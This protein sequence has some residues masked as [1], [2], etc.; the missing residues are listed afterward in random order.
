MR[1]SKYVFFPSLYLFP[2]RGANILYLYIYIYIYIVGTEFWKHLCAEHGVSED[3]TPLEMPTNMSGGA[4]SVD[5]KD[6]FFYEADDE[7]YVPR[8][9]LLDLEPSVVRHVQQS[10]YG[11][12]YNS[13]NMFTMQSGAGNNWARGYNEAEK[14]ASRVLRMIDREAEECDSLE[15][16]ML[17]HS[18]AGGTGSGM[19]SYLL[20]AL[21]DNYPKKVTASYSVFPQA[22]D[23]NVV[24]GPY[25]SMLTMKRLALNADAVVVLDNAAL[26]RIASDRLR[27]EAASVEDVNSLAAT[28][29]AATTSTIRFPGFLNSSLTSIVASL[30]P[31][32]RCHFLMSSYTPWTA[33]AGATVQSVRKTSVLDVMRRLLDSSNL[34]ASTS[35]RRGQFLSLLNIVQ[36]DS[37]DSTQV[38]KGLQ[39]IRE[40]KLATFVPWAPASIQVSIARSSPYLKSAHRVSGVMIANHTAVRGIFTRICKEYDRMRRV[41]ANLNHFQSQG[42]LFADGLDEFDESREVVRQLIDEYRRAES[43]S[44]IDPASNNGG[45]SN[46]ASSSSS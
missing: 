20:E 2:C 1:Q 36:G 44:Y 6:V 14:V 17:C 3:G 46:R 8:A 5:R 15:G 4:Q 11:R 7:H 30:V 28:V 18:I 24:V 21:S 33:R 37:I 34:T 35:M 40:R 27:L 13:E 43:L 22:S 10:R 31:T 42:G 26:N 32:P 25:N 16:F 39:R 41:K 45:G 12:L 29:M 19:G 23:A 38:H 9:L